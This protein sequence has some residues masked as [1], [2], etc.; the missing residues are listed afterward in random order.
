ME[1]PQGGGE[2]RG[3]PVRVQ[4]GGIRGAQPGEQA[5][6]QPVQLRERHGR[7]LGPDERAL[8]WP[9]GGDPAVLELPVG[10]QHRVGVDGQRAHHVLDPRELIAPGQVA[11]PQRLLH[12]VHQLEVGRHP[13]RRVQPEGDPGRR[14]RAASRRVTLFIYIHS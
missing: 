12:L 2:Q 7:R 14:V 4:S 8:T 10:L 13:R 3:H 1:I 6:P 11:Q 5:F 9:P